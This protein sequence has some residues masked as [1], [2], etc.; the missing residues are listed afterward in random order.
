M[1]MQ[2]PFEQFEALVTQ[3]VFA[4]LSNAVATF[5]DGRTVD[6]IFDQPYAQSD[7]GS[8]GFAGERPTFRLPSASV[9]PAWW[10]QFAGEAFD[11]VDA[12]ITVRDVLYQVVRHEPDGTGMSTLV[13]ERA[14]A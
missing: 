14:A 12:Q 2:A 13:L 5:D 10:S 6:G 11:V 4:H 1:T 3:E 8:A 7:I 9:P